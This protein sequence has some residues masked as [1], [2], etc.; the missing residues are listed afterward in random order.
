MK[1]DINTLN[2]YKEDGLLMNQSHPTLPLIIWNYSCS[3][4]YTGDWDEITLQCRALVTDFN[5][6]I[7]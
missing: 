4:Q 3:T 7:K 1:F 5:K 6:Y 2:Q